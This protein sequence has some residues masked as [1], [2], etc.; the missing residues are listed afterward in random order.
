MAIDYSSRDAVSQI[1]GNNS[2]TN[3][4]TPLSTPT[5]ID[6]S[7]RDAVKNILTRQEPEQP[8]Q[9]ADRSLAMEPLTSTI[10]GVT[11][12][13]ELYARTYQGSDIPGTVE[14]QVDPL[15][16]FANWLIENKDRFEKTHP[17]IYAPVK[18]ESAPR[19]W[20][21]AGVRAIPLSL[22]ASVPSAIVG[23]AIGGPVGAVV[24]YAGGGATI[25]GLAK[26]NQFLRDVQK[27][28]EENPDK[29]IPA[30]IYQN[31][32]IKVAISEGALEGL[33]D[34][35]EAATFKVGGLLTKPMKSTIKDI[36][37]QGLKENTKAYVKG[38]AVLQP[39]EMATEA[40]Q[41]FN[42]NAIRLDLGMDAQNPADAALSVLGPT[43]VSTLIMG[44]GAHTLNVRQNSKIAK[45]LENPET[46]FDARFD[47]MRVMYN[48]LKKQDKVNGTNFAETWGKVAQYKLLNKEGINITEALSEIKPV[49]AILKDKAVTEQLNTDVAKFDERG[50]EKIV[51]DVPLEQPVNDKTI[52]PTGHTLE[53]RKIIYDT[54]INK[55]FGEERANELA[56]R[57]MGA[58]EAPVT[59]ATKLVNTGILDE[60]GN[61][62]QKE[63]PLDSTN[64]SIKLTPGESILSNLPEGLRNQFVYKHSGGLFSGPGNV[65]AILKKQGLSK[66]YGPLLIAPGEW[67]GAPL[68]IINMIK[69]MKGVTGKIT[70]QVITPVN[71]KSTERTEIPEAEYNKVQRDDLSN[72]GIPFTNKI[73]AQRAIIRQQKQFNAPEDFY[74][75]VKIGDKQF[76]ARPKKLVKA[77]V[78]IETARDI[79]NRRNPEYLEAVK[80]S[81]QDGIK[82]L[83]EIIQ[84]LKDEGHEH[85]PAYKQT[86]QRREI[87]NRRMVREEKRRAK[88]KGKNKGRVATEKQDIGAQSQQTRPEQVG[89]RKEGETGTEVQGQGKKKNVVAFVNPKQFVTELYSF[90]QGLFNGKSTQE[91]YNTLLDKYNFT[92]DAFIST[93]DSLMDAGYTSNWYVDPNKVYKLLV[94]TFKVKPDI[95]RSLID[96]YNWVPDVNKELNEID[97][98]RKDIRK[99]E[100]G[101]TIVQGQGK[102]KQAVENLKAK[103]KEKEEQVKEKNLKDRLT[104]RWVTARLKLGENVSD[105]TVAKFKTVALRWSRNLRMV[106]GKNMTRV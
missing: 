94:S 92:D 58:K 37:G 5:E 60:L 45:A 53:T 14:G 56:S 95:A 80:V 26:Y 59:P 100:S 3:V 17:Y 71:T 10:A 66:E 97:E 23:S 19:R 69:T 16:Q 101:L 87:I 81:D 51:E 102:A 76:V 96:Q 6:Y 57:I 70:P 65:K 67:V 73:S 34:L 82:K 77:P 46:D 49:E 91:D 93:D 25:F 9:F 90:A 41:E 78:K 55:G 33:N 20:L 42:E 27:Y 44:A 85:T 86:V 50:K 43:F 18:D 98:V 68:P 105:E 103:V 38:Q 4:S 32:A 84:N 12:L 72:K 64:E 99:K 88:D 106:N 61:N 36:L 29:A 28:N 7:S 1:L 48:E 39:S 89:G 83:D 63:V 15:N 13:V 79:I 47:A 52:V 62:I 35:I 8:G 21:R 24:G 40:A 75:I 54:L 11:D 30:E 22:G 2:L 104:A 31:N 74:E